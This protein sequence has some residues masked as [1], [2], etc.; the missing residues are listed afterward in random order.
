MSQNKTR[1]ETWVSYNGKISAPERIIR[2]QVI[3]FPSD[4]VS[5]SVSAGA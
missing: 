3:H 4:L 1:N 5:G 2:G